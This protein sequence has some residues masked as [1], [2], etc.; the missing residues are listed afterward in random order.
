MVGGVRVQ[1]DPSHLQK[2]ADVMTKDAAQKLWEALVAARFNA[3]LG[4]RYNEHLA[5]VEQYTVHMPSDESGVSMDQLRALIRIGEEH[6]CRIFLRG[7]ALR[8]APEPD[9]EMR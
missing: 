3:T 2:G 8:F 5:P 6:G 7:S 9:E 4:C 1:Q